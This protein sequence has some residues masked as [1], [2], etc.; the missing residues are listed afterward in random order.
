MNKYVLLFSQFN[1]T[2]RPWTLV[3]SAQDAKH[4]LQIAQDT[5][6]DWAAS[7]TV[8]IVEVDGIDFSMEQEGLAKNA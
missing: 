3:V 7:T 5:W 4:A 8:Q 2:G 6:F 1:P